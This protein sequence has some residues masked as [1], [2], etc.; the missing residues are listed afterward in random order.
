MGNFIPE[1]VI[2]EIK[3]RN[4]I[5]EVVGSYITLKRTGSTYKAC[6]PFHKEKTPSFNVNPSLQIFKC[7]GCGES[8]NVFSFL[9]KH[10][11]MEFVTAAKTLADRVGISIELEN[12]NGASKHR[13]LIYEIN[14]GIAKFYQRCLKTAP[15]AKLAREYMQSRKLEGEMADSFQVGYAP[16]GWTVSST[17]AKKY[18]YSMDQLEE[19]G[20]VLRSQKENAR[21]KFYDRFR[22]RL[23]FPIHDSQ[24][25]VIGFSARILIEDKKA[26]KYVNSPETPVFHK[27][28][29]LYGLD[30]ARKH[31][32][33]APNRE[34]VICEGQ[35]DVVRCHLAGI[36][37]AIA[38]QGTAFTADH[39]R[40][41][42]NYADSIVLA[43]DS[44]EAGKKAAIKTAIIFMDA[45]IAVRIAELPDGEDPDSFIQANGSVPF[46]KLL[47][48]ATSLITFQI[49]TL[50]SKES[51][52]NSVDATS[53]I[54]NAVLHSICH[55]SNAVQKARLL[56]EA[57]KMLNIPEKALE[58][59]LVKIV[60][61]EKRIA[62][63]QAKMPRRQPDA[64]I[65]QNTPTAKQQASA[66]Y[67][68]EPPP[69]LYDDDGGIEQSYNT[70][71]TSTQPPPPRI[72]YDEQLLC[73]HVVHIVDYPK[74]APLIKEYLP[75][76]MVTNPN[77]RKLI[78]CALDALSQNNDLLE[79]LLAEG[80]DFAE[81]LAYAEKLISTPVKVTGKR[82]FLP[83]EAVQDIILNMW[84]N[85]LD[86][87]RREIRAKGNT[88]TTEEG[89]RRRQITLDL[90]SMRR[91]ETGHDIINI[92]R[93]LLE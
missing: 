6:C 57:A 67:E 10:Q 5:V 48:D 55:S 15:G 2:E 84:R 76:K 47:E 60:A 11:G 44:D 20:I 1:Q 83:A 72:P 63:R 78:T 4:D 54:A 23:M 73:E 89:V 25:R 24:G 90:K 7:F 43:F 21:N 92:E 12:D 77:C 33:N 8:G 34:A 18:N 65:A 79:E 70:A 30:K 49:K 29:V 74:L 28:R 40:S 9:M 71:G 80:D 31:I 22:N 82:E 51:D 26:P 68:E 36:N 91:W 93:E 3:F 39:A 88:L 53:R 41:L 87:E 14:D 66:P 52:A 81:V 19:A 13:K 59:D 50:S 17:W 45:G 35:I 69:D 38:A 58:E 46:R 27:S 32:V 62:E 86:A 16:D 42:K 56:Q 37:T 61:E 85:K 75:I 64:T